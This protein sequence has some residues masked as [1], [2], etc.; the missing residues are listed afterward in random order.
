[1]RAGHDPPL[2]EKLIWEVYHEGEGFE[3][4]RIDSADVT[5]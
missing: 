5:G 1:M 2:R 3:G 4:V